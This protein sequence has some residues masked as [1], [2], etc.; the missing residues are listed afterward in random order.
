MEERNYNRYP[1]FAYSQQQ[2]P[3]IQ[4]PSPYAAY[5]QYNPPAQLT[6]YE[7]FAKPVQPANLMGTAP[8]NHPNSPN[9]HGQGPSG[10]MGQFTD[11]NGQMDFDKMIT[12]VGQIAGTYHQVSPIVKQLSSLMK[13]V[14]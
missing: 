14:R 13:L 4:Q 11:N 12:V 6:P 8:G 1:P 5:P 2:P 3:F 10:I 9:S 7:L